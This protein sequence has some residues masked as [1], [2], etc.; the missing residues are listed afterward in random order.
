[1]DSD[2]ELDPDLDLELD[3]ANGLGGLGLDSLDFGSDSASAST[4]SF[5]S[6]PLIDFPSSSDD[7]GP[8]DNDEA[9]TPLARSQIGRAHV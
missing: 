3:L 2:P 1:M 6:S 9:A 4:P 8:A 7:E 5:N